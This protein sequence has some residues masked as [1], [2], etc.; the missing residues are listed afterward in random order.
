MRSVPVPSRRIDYGAAAHLCV[1][2]DEI[3]TFIFVELVKQLHHFP[4]QIESIH[5]AASELE[6]LKTVSSAM[7]PLCIEDSTLHSSAVPLPSLFILK[8]LFESPHI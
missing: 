7:Q 8:C 6:K 4:L 2:S 5:P 3:Q 1:C